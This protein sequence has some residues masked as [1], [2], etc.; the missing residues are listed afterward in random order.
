M[1]ISDETWNEILAET[2]AGINRLNEI[3]TQNGTADKF[4]WVL[5]GEPPD[6]PKT[7]ITSN[8]N[9]AYRETRAVT[10]NPHTQ[11]ASIVA[12]GRKGR[13]TTLK[14]KKDT[15]AWSKM[16]GKPAKDI[17]RAA[18]LLDYLIILGARATKAPTTAAGPAETTP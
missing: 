12:T 16:S 18:R 6:G 15:K 11:Q 10:R 7:L 14:P 8:V 2:E 9:G 17:I 3:A 4:T 13:F 1:I 5:M